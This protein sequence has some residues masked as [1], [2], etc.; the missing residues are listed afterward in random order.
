MHV[1]GAQAP[2]PAVCESAE[3]A[4]D[5]PLLPEAELPKKKNTKTLKFFDVSTDGSDRPAE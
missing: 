2:A 3:S 4:P 1:L 5:A